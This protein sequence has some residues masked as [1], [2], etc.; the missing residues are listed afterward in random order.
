[1][2]SQFLSDISH[3][4]LLTFRGIF[5][6]WIFVYIFNASH[7]DELLTFYGFLGR[8]L[9]FFWANWASHRW[10]FD[11]IPVLICW[12]YWGLCGWLIARFHDPVGRSAVLG[13]VLSYAF[14]SAF[15]FASFA[16]APPSFYETDHSDFARVLVIWAIRDTGIIICALTS[17]RALSRRPLVL[18]AG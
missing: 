8:G 17:G 4:K 6:G 3:H 15:H 18:S 14:Y 5:T 16:A 11:L 1:M 13:F 10:V 9:S 2:A 7:D 12:I